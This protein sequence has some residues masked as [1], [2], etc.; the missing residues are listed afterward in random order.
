MCSVERL[1]QLHSEGRISDE[2]LDKGLK[3]LDIAKQTEKNAEPTT[4]AF[5]NM[6]K[7]RRNKKIR[8]RQQQNNDEKKL[9]EELKLIDKPLCNYFKAYEIDVHRYNDFN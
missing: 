9:V 5:D 4:S 3:S 8:K 7:R 1:L 6:R 2:A